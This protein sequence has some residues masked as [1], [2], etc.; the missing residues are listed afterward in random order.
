MSG[1]G[2]GP[3]YSDIEWFAL[4]TNRDHS[5]VFETEGCTLERKK[6]KMSVAQSC[7][8]L[9]NHMDSV[10]GFLQARILEWVAIPSSRGLPKPGI[11]LAS[12]ALSGGFFTT[13]P[14]RRPHIGYCGEC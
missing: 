12:P 4:K 10:H 3:N 6:V 11:E 7:P 1:R 8:T 14:P 2:I 5:V 13:V 9:F